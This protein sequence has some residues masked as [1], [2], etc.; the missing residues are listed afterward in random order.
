MYGGLLNGDIKWKCKGEY[1]IDNDIFNKV[2]NQWDIE[3]ENSKL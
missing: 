1:T 2:S 3:R